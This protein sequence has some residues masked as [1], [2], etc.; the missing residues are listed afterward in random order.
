MDLTAFMK[1]YADQIGGQFTQYD[2][3]HSI[4]IMPVSGNRFQTVIG[5]IRKN[6]LYNRSLI[7]LNSKVCTIKHSLDYKMLLEQAAYFNYCRFVVNENHLQIEA[8][9]AV[10][11]TTEG[12]LTEMLQEVANLADQYEL[13]LTDSDIH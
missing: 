1:K 3:S 13:K 4:I 8:V 2:P 9:T 10:D 6:E 12:T 11:A 7:T 5:T